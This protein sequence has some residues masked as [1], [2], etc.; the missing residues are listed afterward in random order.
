MEEFQKLKQTN[1]EIDNLI[2]LYELKIREL[3]IEKN[4]FISEIDLIKEEKNKD[5][6]NNIHSLS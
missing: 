6:N 3:E 5:I 1:V 2:K 4:N